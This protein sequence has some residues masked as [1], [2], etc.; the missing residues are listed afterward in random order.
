MSSADPLGRLLRMQRAL[1]LLPSPDVP[2]SGKEGRAPGLEL[3]HRGRDRLEE[4]AVVRDEQDAGVERCELALE[5]L[6]ARD[7]EV[8]GRLVE[9]QHVGVAGERARER[10]ARE[11]ATGEGVQ[12]PV[13]VVVAEP[14]PANDARRSLAPRVAARMLEPGLGAGVAPQGRGTVVA[15]RHRRLELAQLPF[16]RDKPCGSAQHVLAQ[17]EP[18]AQRRALVVERD[19]R[20]LLERELTA[21][22]LGLA[23]EDPQQRRLAGAVRP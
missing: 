6:E 7:V 21:V 11:L 16:E 22:V 2:G 9:Q 19:A 18:A 20:A 3:E 10:A 5:P 4:P 14:E 23:G 15:G 17:R 13:E 8:V 12:R 1:R